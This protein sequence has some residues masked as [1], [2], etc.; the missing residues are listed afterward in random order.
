MSRYTAKAANIKPI[1][2]TTLFSHNLIKEL[3]NRGASGYW[4][5]RLAKT[6][7]NIP[8]KNGLKVDT[9]D[10]ALSFAGY[11]ISFLRDH[12]SRKIYVFCAGEAVEMDT[13]T[14][15]ASVQFTED[16]ISFLEQLN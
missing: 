10:N 4:L 8:S 15:A 6:I 16:F 3:K 14:G 1:R 7:E 5:R 2:Y 11:P 9:S 12:N 13:K